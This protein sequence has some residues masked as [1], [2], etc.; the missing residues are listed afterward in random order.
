MNADLGDIAADALRFLHSR[1]S[2]NHLGRGGQHPS[3]NKLVPVFQIAANSRFIGGRFL[4][5]SLLDGT[6]MKTQHYARFRPA[7]H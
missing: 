7:R 4:Q 1:E 2:G 5:Q 3:L 6:H